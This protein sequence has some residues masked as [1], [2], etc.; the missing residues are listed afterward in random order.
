MNIVT[1]RAGQN[2]D[3]IV[4]EG[5]DIGEGIVIVNVSAS[6]PQL[7]SDHP[8]WVAVTANAMDSTTQNASANAASAESPLRQSVHPAALALLPTLPIPWSLP[9]W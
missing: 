5:F 1:K 7:S 8:I 9:I 2:S 6:A 4:I 3:G